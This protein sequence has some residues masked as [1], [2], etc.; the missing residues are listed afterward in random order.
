[1][2]YLYLS[3]GKLHLANPGGSPRE[4]RSDYAL[5][6]QARHEQSQRRHAWKQE[7]GAG[8]STGYAVWNQGRGLGGEARVRI[9]S[10]CPAR[11]SGHFY[12]L[13]ETDVVGGLFR[14]DPAEGDERRLFHK[15]RFHAND[16]A[17]HP[18]RP[19][20]ACAV[21]S[22][23]GTHLAVIRDERFDVQYLTEGDVL[24]GGPCWDPK[25]PDAL[26]Y[27]S[28]GI[29]RTQSGHHTGLEASRI[30][31]LG[32]TDGRQETVLESP[33]VDFLNPRPDTQGR[34]LCIRRPHQ[35]PG[36]RVRHSEALKDFMLAPVRV[37][38]AVFGFINVMTQ[39]FA[40]ESLVKAHNGQKMD[41]EPKAAFIKGRLLD[42]SKVDPNAPESSPIPNDWELIRREPDGSLHVLAQRVGDFDLAP[43]GHILLTDGR[44]VLDLAPDGTRTTLHQGRD[45]IESVRWVE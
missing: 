41:V 35:G 39:I 28:A 15:E 7:S 9:V 40:K 10:A 25:D 5:Q 17:P 16:L 37:I 22:P 44:R 32:T 2:P 1:M 4:I 38:K 42:L 30:M 11:P 12:Y 45:L 20:L 29:G 31:R 24:D 26:Y 14:H 21:R 6:V 18:T 8:G 23:D 13:L 43:G 3:G 19:W 33:Q 36:G 27:H 34:L